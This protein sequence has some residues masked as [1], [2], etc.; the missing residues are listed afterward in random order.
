MNRLI[1]LKEV[2][3]QLGCS[4]TTIQRQIQAD[5]MTTPIRIGRRILIPSVEV[6]AILEHRIKGAS[7]DDIRQLV[8]ELMAKRAEL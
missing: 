5:T 6:T 7:D 1:G 8:I 4:I 3:A 2:G